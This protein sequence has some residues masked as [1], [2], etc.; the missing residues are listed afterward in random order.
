MPG[1]CQSFPGQGL[2]PCHNYNPEPQ[3][4]QCQILNPE[5]PG[6]SYTNYFKHNS[7]LWKLCFFIYTKNKRNIILSHKHG[8]NILCHFVSLT[9][10][11]P[12]WAFYVKVSF[13]EFSLHSAH[14]YL[15]DWGGNRLELSTWQNKQVSKHQCIAFIKIIIYITG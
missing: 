10:C 15:L 8:I 5:S 11:V 2:N 4:W 12:T 9:Y 3:Q 13:F 14:G 6:N 1:P 7:R